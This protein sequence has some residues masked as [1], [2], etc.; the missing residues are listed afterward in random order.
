DRTTAQI[1]VK[2]ADSVSPAVV[3]VQASASEVS[4]PNKSVSVEFTKVTT[5]VENAVAKINAAK[6]YVND[7]DLYNTA[8]RVTTVNDTN[9]A[10]VK[11]AV[12]VAYTNNGGDL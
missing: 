8:A 5:A 10:A 6:G 9:L 1:V 11:D 7:K 12:A 2:T 4:L 3:N